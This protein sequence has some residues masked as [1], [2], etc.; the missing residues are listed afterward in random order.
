MSQVSQPARVSDISAAMSKRRPQRLD[1]STTALPFYMPADPTRLGFPFPCTA[2]LP[3]MFHPQ[4]H[5]LVH[6][7]QLYALATAASASCHN[8]TFGR[9]QPEQVKTKRHREPPSKKAVSAFTCSSSPNDNI[10]IENSRVTRELKERQR[11]NRS[12]TT[13]NDELKLFYI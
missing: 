7:H 3:G 2:P 11:R 6:N 9:S 10:F 5:P 12:K 4:P 8:L 13:T 1:L